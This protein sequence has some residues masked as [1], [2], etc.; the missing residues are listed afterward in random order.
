MVAWYHGFMTAQMTIRLPDDLY[1]ALREEC[2]SSRQS[3]N[4]IIADGL[5]LRLPPVDPEKYTLLCNLFEAAWHH[6]VPE[7]LNDLA[8]VTSKEARALALLATEAL[9]LPGGQD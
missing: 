3:M 1:E 4:A 5:R 6:D 2:F 7:T 9:S 8:P